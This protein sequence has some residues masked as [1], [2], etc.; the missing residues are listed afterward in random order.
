[1]SVQATDVIKVDG[2]ISDPRVLHIS[3]ELGTVIQRHEDDG[4]DGE[5]DVTTE[6]VAVLLTALVL[7]ATSACKS[8]GIHPSNFVEHFENVYAHTEPPDVIPVVAGS[9]S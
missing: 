2:Y 9:E 5:G 8:Y 6:T 7:V 4:E 1:M 3:S